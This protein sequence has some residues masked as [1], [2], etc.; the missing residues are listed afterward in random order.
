[1]DELERQKIEEAEAT[2]FDKEM[3]LEFYRRGDKMLS[4]FKTGENTGKYIFPN[5]TEDVDKIIEGMPYRCMVKN[6]DE[7]G[8][9]FA[10]IISQ[11]YIPRLIIRKGFVVL[12][13]RGSKDQIE[14]V[15]IPSLRKA[16][17]VLA[18][19]KIYRWL[20]IIQTNDFNDEGEVK[21]DVNQLWTNR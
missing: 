9:A 4:R 15:A 7:C 1:M 2:G 3:I 6:P 14:H 16:L 20:T 10:K 21:L 17:S 8:A 18:E 11:V 19:K 5:R 12:A 13:L